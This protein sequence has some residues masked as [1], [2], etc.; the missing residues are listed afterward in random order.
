M[1]TDG[2]EKKN[3]PSL[4][5]KHIIGIFINSHGMEEG[6]GGRRRKDGSKDEG[7]EKERE[8]EG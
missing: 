4:S 7:K 8:E 3:H 6:R 5:F 1:D 2:R